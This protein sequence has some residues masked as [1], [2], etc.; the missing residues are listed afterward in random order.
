M[1]ASFRTTTIGGYHLRRWAGGFSYL[2][3]VVFNTPILDEDVREKL[4]DELPSFDIR[5]RYE[6]ALNFRNYLTAV[7]QRSTLR[8]IYFGRMEIIRLGSHEFEA[9]R[10][11]ADHIYERRQLQRGK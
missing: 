3:A 4:V 7:W 1:P 9:A 11:A 2:D 6:R 10:V 5:H 8:P